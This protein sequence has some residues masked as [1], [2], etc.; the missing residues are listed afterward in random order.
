MTKDTSKSERK[1]N[2]FSIYL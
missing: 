1:R 2:W